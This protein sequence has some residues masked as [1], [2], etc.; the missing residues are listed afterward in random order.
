M[1]NDDISNPT[2]V[3]KGRGA[4]SNLAGRFAKQIS[5]REDD[6]WQ[7]EEE[8]LER[9]LTEAIEEKA[10]TIISSNNSPDL[11]FSQSINP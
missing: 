5:S 11:P 9:L 6:G 1:A 8:P 10:K 7:L 2:R 3:H 4:A